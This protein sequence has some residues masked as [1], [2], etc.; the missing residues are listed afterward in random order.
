MKSTTITIPAVTR[1]ENVVVKKTVV[2]TPASAA[3]QLT[4]TPREAQFIATVLAHRNA[5]MNGYKSSDKEDFSDISSRLYSTTIDF[6]EEH[7]GPAKARA[8]SL[9][10]SERRRVDALFSRHGGCMPNTRD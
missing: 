4:L 2:V 9:W 6:V 8:T 10:Q 3:L 1:E 5:F 7:V